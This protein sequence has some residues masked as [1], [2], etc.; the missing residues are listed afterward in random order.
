[1]EG[2]TQADDEGILGIEDGDAFP[3]YLLAGLQDA[4]GRVGRRRG[5]GVVRIIQGLDINRLREDEQ[6]VV[7]LGSY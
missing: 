4:Y 1:M 6:V 7:Y 5:R 3:I 2:R